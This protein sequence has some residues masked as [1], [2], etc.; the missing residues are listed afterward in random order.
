[1]VRIQSA[2]PSAALTKC[3]PERIQRSF[4]ERLLSW[5]QGLK[6]R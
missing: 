6:K 3:R 4:D 2:T 5:E 1:M